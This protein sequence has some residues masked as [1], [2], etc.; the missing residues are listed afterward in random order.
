[1]K[2]LM[3]GPDAM[4]RAVTSWGEAAWML[5]RRVHDKWG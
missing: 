4:R 1:M 2:R 3:D 5:R